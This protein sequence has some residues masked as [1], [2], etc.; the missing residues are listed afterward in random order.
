MKNPADYIMASQRNGTLY[1]GVT[2]NLPR[3]AY[4]HREAVVPGFMA[5]YGC[6]LLVWF[7]SRDD[8]KRHRA[9]ETNQGRLTQEKTS[10]DRSGESVM[11]RSL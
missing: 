7:E 9:G 10:A 5:R 11:A 3:R 1:T 4:E 2:S 8:G 6:K